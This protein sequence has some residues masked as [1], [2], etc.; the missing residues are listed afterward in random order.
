M[1]FAFHFKSIWFSSRRSYRPQYP[2]SAHIHCRPMGIPISS[3]SI[4]LVTNYNPNCVSCVSCVN[5]R[6]WKTCIGATIANSPSLSSSSGD[7]ACPPKWIT[8]QKKVSF[9]TKMI[10]KFESRLWELLR[11]CYHFL[12][13]AWHSIG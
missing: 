8:W 9:E 11:W 4:Q 7:G 13:L 2:M 5:C 3:V 1:T 10:Y 12:S 6:I